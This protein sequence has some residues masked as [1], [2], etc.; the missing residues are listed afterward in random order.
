MSKLRVS[1]VALVAALP[2]LGLAADL[3][4]KKA[5]VAPPPPF[6]WDGWYVGSSFGY[7]FANEWETGWDAL[8]GSVG[9]GAG[10]GL[11]GPA[12]YQQKYN[13]RG[14]QTDFHAGYLKQWDHFVGGGE[15]DIGFATGQTNK[16]VFN[17]LLN[18]VFPGG[19]LTGPP[20]FPAG[21]TGLTIPP[22]PA[23][24]QTNIQ[25]NWNIS[26]IGK[27]GYADGRALYY[28]LGG[29]VSG[30]YDVRHN[31]WGMPGVYQ[32]FGYATINPNNDINDIERFGWTVGAGLEYAFTN[33][34][35]A[36][37]EYRHVD[38]GNAH[39]TSTGNQNS[40]LNLPGQSILTAAAVG[41]APGGG[42]FGLNFTERLT[43]DNI[44]LGLNYHFN[45]TPAPV[46]APEP[47]PKGPTK[48]EPPKVAAEPDPSFIGRLY[49]AYADEWGLGSP[50]D[51]PSA[52]PS[53]RKDFPPA[54]V[55]SGPYPFTEWPMG[56]SNYI[57]ATTP[58]SI[59]S[60]FMKALG[61]TAVGKT[62]EDWH[63]Q[64]YG[65]FNP[66]FNVSNMRSLPG[67]VT[68]GNFPA[69]YSYQP[70]VIQLDQIVTIIERL[71][72]TVQQDHIDWGFR[73]SPLYGETYRYTTALG[74]TSDQLQKWNKFAGFDAPMIYGE[75]YVP[76][77]FEGLMLRLGRF[78]S[79]PDIEAQLA[80][81]N[82]MYSHSMTY[83]YDNYTTTGLETTWQ[84]TKNW[85]FQLGILVGTDS[86]LWNGRQASYPALLAGS[87]FSL[88][89]GIWSTIPAGYLS[90]GQAAYNGQVDNGIQ[91]SLTSCLRYQTDDA[92]N[93][94]YSCANGINTGG[95][96]YNNLQQF[97]TTFYHKFNDQ[98][99]F[100]VEAWDMHTDSTPNFASPLFGAT[101]YPWFQMLNAYN[102][103]IC[104]TDL[105]SHCTAREWAILTY[106]NWEF[107]PQD[108]L[109]W[110]AEYFD[111]IT[112]QR[113][114]FKTSYFNYAMGWQHWFTPTITIRPEVA[115]YNSL[116]TPAF[117][118]GTKSHATIFSA[119]IIWHY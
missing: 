16:T 37:V 21:V 56:G 13:P 113:T 38:L 99:H 36:N 77:I 66:G 79:V 9:F 70:N 83:G 71:P 15:F 51:D 39:V 61:P 98:W 22:G 54:P 102:G 57:G 97:T 119:D 29:L 69:A 89:P 67:Q 25:Q 5:P 10:Y 92:Y 1:L 73:L 34:W 107:S 28:L 53:R 32:S 103:A 111:D 47:A 12:W 101:P 100:S 8:P 86:M 105:N 81:N 42:I 43:E 46:A 106:L 40:G 19:T 60:P 48:K 33:E 24:F 23:P 85:T 26:L 114:G 52:P 45:G 93:A 78:I 55:T 49:H 75:L 96:G 118:N 6:S 35:S 11:T 31:Y 17:N 82:Y 109:S 76:G 65:W 63:I 62:L 74:F 95:Y 30:G 27:A 72:D 7:G 14:L 20:L 108:N 87:V 94:I 4:S 84:L 110:R 116:K 59:D 88:A 104:Q 91:P 90:A 44:R 2:S 41:G 64:V 3:P 50:P 112:G 18:T 58:N 80:P 117:E 68:G 115:F